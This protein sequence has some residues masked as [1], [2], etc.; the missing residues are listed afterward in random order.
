ML[1]P[2][3]WVC[4][5]TKNIQHFSYYSMGFLLV[6]REEIRDLYKFFSCVSVFLSCMTLGSCYTDLGE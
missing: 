4:E 5:K 2:L 6:P 3:M 1:A